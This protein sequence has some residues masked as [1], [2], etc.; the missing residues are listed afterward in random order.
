MGILS[1][2]KS[3]FVESQ[4]RPFNQ[5]CSDYLKIKAELAVSDVNVSGKETNFKVMWR[6]SVVPFWVSSKYQ[7]SDIV[8]VI[9][10]GLAFGLN[11]VEISQELKNYGL[12]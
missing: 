1:K 3:L 7:V 11:L 5:F 10:A 9:A 2:I 8:S 6:G 12:A 4:K